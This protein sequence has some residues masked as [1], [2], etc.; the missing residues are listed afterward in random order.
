M[1]IKKKIYNKSMADADWNGVKA[2]INFAL[3]NPVRAER[4]RNNIEG[5]R[6]TVEKS[7]PVIKKMVDSLAA[8]FGGGQNDKD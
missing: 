5:I 3:D 2:G 7:M 6:I 1:K 8:C 4:Y